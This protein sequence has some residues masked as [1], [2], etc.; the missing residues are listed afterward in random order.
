MR[1]GY[2]TVASFYDALAG[3]IFGD[4]QLQAQEYLLSHIPP[5]SNVLIVGGGSGWILDAINKLH[6]SGLTITY[7]DASRGMMALAKQRATAGHSITF[8]ADSIENIK[9]GDGSFDIVITPFLFDNFTAPDC[10][11]IFVKL[12]KA[13]NGNGAWLF[14]DFRQPVLW[15]H[16]LLLKTMYL[17]F[18]IIAG[19]K[20]KQ[21]PGTDSLFA[22]AGYTQVAQR[23]YWDGFISAM[24]YEHHVQK[25]NSKF[26]K[27]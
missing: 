23:E 1:R 13:L 26:W 5:N 6:P 21:L 24:V 4:V 3:L 9:L 2:D 7:I 16:K 12:H 17:F 19:I 15:K 20:A 18:G 27:E 10:K 14:A 11:S 22:E 8:I 25:N